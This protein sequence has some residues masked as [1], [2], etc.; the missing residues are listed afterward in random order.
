MSCEYFIFHRKFIIAVSVC[1]FTRDQP[2]QCNNFEDIES[3]YCKEHNV[4]L[5]DVN[6]KAFIFQNHFHFLRMIAD[7]II[8]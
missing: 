7:S 5:I 8:G 3:N 6:E 4:Y 1:Y 2:F